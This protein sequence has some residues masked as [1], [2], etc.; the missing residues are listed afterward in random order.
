[1][2]S[3]FT[4]F[5]L[6]PILLLLLAAATARG[7]QKQSA[8]ISLEDRHFIA[9]KGT[10]EIPAE[11][12]QQEQNQPH[13]AVRSGDTIVLRNRDK[14][15]WRPLS[16]TPENQF[17]TPSKG[18]APGQSRT[19]IAK[20]TTDKPIRLK[21]HDD[22]HAY[23]KMVI[24]VLPAGEEEQGQNTFAG[25][26][27][28][29]WGTAIIQLSGDGKTATG[30]YTYTLTRGG[31]AHGK[32]SGTVVGNKLTGNWSE[33]FDDRKAAGTMTLTLSEDGGSF[34]GP[35]KKVS[36]RAAEDSGE[37]KGTRQKK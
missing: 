25:T 22:I 10:A 24:V 35:W 26:W 14:V 15:Y 37:W 20:N 16:K 19:I 18:L 17:T 27:M 23:A 29:T 30:T 9:G 36:G 33:S 8:E 3:L 28:T 12:L 31:K 7:G 11:M 21:I 4:S 5:R 2:R 32:I 34:A 13:M 1:M 6:L